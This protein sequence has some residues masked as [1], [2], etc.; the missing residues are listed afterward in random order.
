MIT[1][2]T[3]D[4][5]SLP[6]VINVVPRIK[7]LICLSKVEIAVAWDG[8]GRLANYTDISS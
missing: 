4:A 6:K 1:K 5:H 7:I 8:G 2:P 3:G